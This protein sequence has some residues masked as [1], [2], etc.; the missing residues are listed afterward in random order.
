MAEIGTT[1][2]EQRLQ[3]FITVREV[4]GELKLNPQTVKRWLKEKRVPK[5]TWG[6]DRRGWVFIHRESV[7]LLR[8]YRDSIKIN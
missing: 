1:I 2:G 7:K 3:D 4:A 5:V 8:Q 6:K